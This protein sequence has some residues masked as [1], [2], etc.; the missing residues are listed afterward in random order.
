MPSP[1]GLAWRSSRSAR[2]Y[3]AADT[4]F[5]DCVIFWMLVTDFR[6]IWIC[7]S[8]A[9]ERVCCGTAAP[10]LWRSKNQHGANKKE[11]FRKSETSEPR[12]PFNTHRQT[13]F[14]GLEIIII[15][16]RSCFGEDA[17]RWIFCSERDGFGSGGDEKMANATVTGSNKGYGATGT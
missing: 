16:A 2:A 10:L 14:A 6:R 7:L 11:T 9:M 5:M 3:L 1:Y 12:V 4:I 8:V 15:A 13:S 17:C